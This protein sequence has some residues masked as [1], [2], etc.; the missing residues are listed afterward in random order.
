ME[1]LLG[2]SVSILNLIVYGCVCH[3]PDLV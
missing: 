3:R 1:M 2:L